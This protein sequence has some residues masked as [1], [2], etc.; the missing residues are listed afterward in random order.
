MPLPRAAY[1]VRLPIR[2]L[3]STPRS[4][5]TSRLNPPFV[6]MNS[7]AAIGMPAVPARATLRR[8]AALASAANCAGVF[9][10]SAYPPSTD[11]TRIIG[12]SFLAS[13]AALRVLKA[14][15]PSSIGTLSRPRRWPGARAATP[16]CSGRPA[17][18]SDNAVALIDA[19]CCSTGTASYFAVLRAS[20][21]LRSNVSITT[22]PVAFSRITQLAVRASEFVGSILGATPAAST[23]AGRAAG[24]TWAA[25]ASLATG[26]GAWFPAADAM[27]FAE[28]PATDWFSASFAGTALVSSALDASFLGAVSVDAGASLSIADCADCA[29]AVVLF[30]STFASANPPSTSTGSRPPPFCLAAIR[31]CAFVNGAP[32][33]LRNSPSSPGVTVSR[34]S[35]ASGACATEGLGAAPPASDATAPSGA[36]SVPAR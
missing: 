17:G 27:T 5:A 1:S 19:R 26:A 35:R 21:F 13:P 12:C 3:P 20:T 32:R 2:G 11:T 10:A 6:A 33:A 25:A 9:S 31:A 23:P 22:A 7:C 30:G 29:I 16:C 14:L 34:P 18:C 8:R 4:A 24:T 36:R 15:P 28:E